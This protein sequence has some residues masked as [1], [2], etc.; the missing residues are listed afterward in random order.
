[1]AD[2]QRSPT[3]NFRRDGSSQSDI[4]AFQALVSHIRAISPNITETR[5]VIVTNY[6]DFIGSCTHQ[7]FDIAV[8]I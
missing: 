2:G 3:V 8:P 7:I 5:A 1:M 4:G 6:S